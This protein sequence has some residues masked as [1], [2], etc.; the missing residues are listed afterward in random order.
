MQQE[1]LPISLLKHCYRRW[2]SYLAEIN[3]DV[4]ASSPRQRA[5]HI[6]FRESVESGHYALFD[7]GSWEVC[8]FVFCELCLHL[9]GP[10]PAMVFHLDLHHLYALGSQWTVRLQ[11]VSVADVVAG[12][13][14]KQFIVLVHGV[15]HG[16]STAR[17]ADPVEPAVRRE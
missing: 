7:Q 4:E 11:R 8:V 12:H 3:T 13:M 17:G 9:A 14:S 16:V 5:D 10:P 15:E 2:V 6:I 1:H